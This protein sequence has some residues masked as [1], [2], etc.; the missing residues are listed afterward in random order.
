MNRPGEGRDVSPASSVAS[1]TRTGV[2][3]H[4]AAPEGGG[5]ARSC[6]T[7]GTAGHCSGEVAVGE[8]A[9]MRG[10]EKAATSW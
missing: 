7:N 6:I 4:R 3:L 5:T 9:E 2:S 1:A 8:A 10:W